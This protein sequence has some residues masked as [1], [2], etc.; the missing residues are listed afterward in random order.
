MNKFNILIFCAL[1]SIS[2]GSQIAKNKTTYAK[3]NLNG[4]AMK[5]VDG[6]W[7]NGDTFEKK[8]VWINEGLISFKSLDTKVDTILDLSNKYIIP[9]FAEAHN[10]NLESTYELD[11]RI[12][13][14]LDNGVFYVKL[15]SSI[16]KRIDPLMGNY[17]KPDG[18]DVSLAHAPFTATDGHPV[19][20]RKRYFD[21][22]YFD[23]LFN[24]IDDIEFHGYVLIDSELD[25]ENKWD[26]IVSFSPDFIKLNLLYSE[27]YEKRKD[28]SIYFG[29]KGLNPKLVPLIVKKAHTKG[30]RVSAHVE[31]AYDFH[32]A[33]NAGVDEIAHLPEI[34]NGNLIHKKDALLAKEKDIVVI[35]T[36]SLVTKRQKSPNYQHLLNNCTSNLKLLND[37]GVTM[38][39]GS[40]MYNDNS[41]NELQLLY[42]LGVFSN[43]ELLKMWT[44]NATKTT[45]P[46]RKVGK[47]E[48]GYEALFLVLDEK[49][50]NDMLKV[51]KSIILKVKQ[52]LILK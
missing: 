32:V 46:K 30:L 3:K 37:I 26:S 10:H 29:R 7:F 41:T 14:Y 16:K 42:Q 44:E 25:L 39:L 35:T 18:I 20:L 36:V 40:D 19:A 52:G 34:K 27:E 28:D 22:G 13:S 45:F 48:E 11:K 23:G 2:C 6:L 31:T 43:I 15:L 4:K 9:P 5:L 24:S 1:L 49:P 33:V 12:A 38:A 47:L 17:N 8:T 51:N 50:L 21:K